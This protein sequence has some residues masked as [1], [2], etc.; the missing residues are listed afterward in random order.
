LKS[1]DLTS[2][3]ALIYTKIDSIW[4]NWLGMSKDNPNYS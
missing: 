3:L 2:Y 4:P 1:F